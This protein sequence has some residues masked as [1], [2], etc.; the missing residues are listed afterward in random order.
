[1]PGK[2]LPAGIDLRADRLRDAEDDAAGERAPQAAEAADDHG[3]EAEDQPRRPDR[4]IEIGADGEEHAG[5]RHHRERERHRQR[6]DVAVVEAHELR[7]R[8]V[9]GGGAEGAAERGAVEQNLQAADDGDGDDELE[10]RQDAD[11]E[12]SA[13]WKLAT[14][15]APACSRRLSAVNSSSSPFWMMTER[16]N[17][18]SSGGRRSSPSVRLSSARCSA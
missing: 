6:E 11:P 10:E 2:E 16:P 18:T 4:R 3:L 5:D 1:M 7:D 9:V 14:S 12:P 15:I 13:S 17:V 8:R